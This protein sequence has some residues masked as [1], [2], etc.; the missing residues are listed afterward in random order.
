[1]TGSDQISAESHGNETTINKVKEDRCGSI[2]IPISPLT[3]AGNPTPP[4]DDSS[5]G[6][7]WYPQT[8]FTPT[9][10]LSHHP[11]PPS[12]LDP[13][14]A[15]DVY[16]G[17]LQPKF[18]SFYPPEDLEPAEDYSPAYPMYQGYMYRS[19]SAN[20]T[21]S[22]L[23]DQLEPV[24]TTPVQLVYNFPPSQVAHL[25]SSK[26]G[27]L[28]Q[29]SMSEAEMPVEKLSEDGVYS[30]PGPEGS[31]KSINEAP[32]HYHETEEGHVA[33]G[34]PTAFKPHFRADGIDINAATLGKFPAHGAWD[35][36]LH[37]G[38]TDNGL[39]T[40]SLMDFLLQQFNDPQYADCCLHVSYKDNQFPKEDLLLH[41][42]LIARSP[43][44]ASKLASC[45]RKHDGTR[46]LGLEI[47]TSFVTPSALYSALRV[48]YGEPLG[49]FLDRNRAAAPFSLKEDSRSSMAN[50]LAYA[51]AGLL[52]GLQYVT[53]LGLQFATNALDWENI[54]LALSFIL[55]GYVDHGPGEITRDN[56]STPD[57]ADDID[58]SD[59][60]RL[61]YSDTAATASLLGSQ[62]REGSRLARSC[63]QFLKE[64][65][66]NSWKVDLTAAPISQLDR[67][68]LPIITQQPPSTSRLSHIQFGSLQ[69]EAPI[70]PSRF[71]TFS[72]AILLSA[73]YALL[74]DI[75][76]YA[77]YRI[78]TQTMDAII[79]EREQRRQQVL[80][81]K[82]VPNSKREECRDAWVPAGWTEYFDNTD[83]DASTETRFTRRWTG[84]LDPTDT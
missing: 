67:L 44:L 60:S 77:G 83:I 16:Q 17:Y 65:F 24:N 41:S 49:Y 7:S 19:T 58:H 51:G 42:L 75:F 38:P 10:P 47:S 37:D 9:N 59:A 53:E 11:T 64:A 15:D 4:I 56:L 36:K 13:S 45:E 27:G 84:F 18:V 22:H 66:P 40:I 68:P 50:I 20:Q 72:S 32:E 80:M 69:P 57:G 76:C 2:D 62:G 73:P 78:G 46:H 26:R 54:D 61:P 79:T 23:R 39:S 5:T 31:I 82:D 12:D 71:D 33:D 70:G 63:L 3:F 1:M 21:V 25:G 30:S 34:H 81:N 29:S 43:V 52:L 74:K 35:W 28:A 55:D 8:P 14:P 6:V 48:C